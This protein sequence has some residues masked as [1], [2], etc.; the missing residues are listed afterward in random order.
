MTYG[1][2]LSIPAIG[3]KSVLEFAA[4]ADIFTAA[5]VPQI[6]DEAVRQMLTDAADEDWAERAAGDDPRFRDV[7]PAHPA[8][9]A[10]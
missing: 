2:L 10:S 5:P 4:I 7:F 8:C 9:S 1:Q 3:V 6:L